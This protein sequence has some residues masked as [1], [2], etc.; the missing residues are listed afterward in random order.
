MISGTRYPVLPVALRSPDQQR[1][2]HERS[3]NSGLH[4]EADPWRA[5]C[6]FCPLP[7][8]VLPEGGISAG[9][10]QEYLGRCPIV[11]AKRD[12]LAVAEAVK[13]ARALCPK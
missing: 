7:D 8:C 3:L 6:E 13:K 9:H 12:G 2:L 10:T 4:L 1:R 11:T 5:V